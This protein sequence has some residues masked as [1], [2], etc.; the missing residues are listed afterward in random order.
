[1]RFRSRWLIACVALT[2]CVSVGA[3]EL[4]ITVLDQRQQPVAGSVISLESDSAMPATP[5]PSKTRIVDQKDEAFVPYIDIYRLQDKVV[6]HNSDKTRHH[7][8][9]FSPTR[10]FEF[11][12]APGETSTPVGF[13]KPGAIAVGCNIH[14]QMIMY[15]YVS[16]A[17]WIAQAGADG[18][19]RFTD[20]PA[21]SYTVKVWHPQLRPGKIEPPQ[22]ITIGAVDDAKAL[23]FALTLMP[24][25][26][27]SPGRERARY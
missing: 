6:F 25:P 13:D 18:Q 22:S 19:T 15:L 24:D 21:G 8:Y 1:M 12:V 11:V 14:D 27:L 4:A 2:A 20:L 9:S 5:T 17:R 10:S 23:S 26:R 3:G 16:D 7:V